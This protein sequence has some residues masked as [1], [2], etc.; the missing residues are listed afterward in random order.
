MDNVTLKRK[1][2]TFV[3]EGGY[4]KNVSED[5]LYEVLIAWENWTGS[6]KEF[7]RSLGYTYNQLAWIIGKAKRMK[8]EGRFGEGDFKQV[9]VDVSSISETFSSNGARIELVLQ[10]DKIIRFAQVD[11]LVDFLKKSA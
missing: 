3:T 7:Y 5:V 9:S 4:L 8:R 2:S 6:S 1:L 10:S 11:D